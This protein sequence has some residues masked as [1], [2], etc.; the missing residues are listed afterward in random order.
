MKTGSVCATLDDASRLLELYL[1]VIEKGLTAQPGKVRSGSKKHMTL[2]VDSS[3]FPLVVSLSCAS[4][5]TYPGE[6]LT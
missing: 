5:L 4:R 1:Y 3:Y 2:L 6:A